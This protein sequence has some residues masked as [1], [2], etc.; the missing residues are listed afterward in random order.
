MSPLRTIAP[1][2]ALGLAACA[3]TGEGPGTE[4]LGTDVD[5]DGWLADAADPEARDCDDADATV[6]P[7]AAELCDDVDQDCDGHIDEDAV[8]RTTWYTDGDGDGWGDADSAELACDQP[9]GTVDRGGDCDDRAERVNPDA[10]EVCDP[11]R[12][13]EDCDGQADDQDPD[14]DPDAAGAGTWH[15]DADGDGFGDAEDPGA[16]YCH[17]P[18]GASLSFVQDASDCD[19]SREDVNPEGTEVCDEDDTDEDCDGLVDDE[20]DSLKTTSQALWAPDAD[21]DGY[22]DLRAAE[23]RCDAPPE[24]TVYWAE[25]AS[26][27]DDERAD[28]NPGAQEVCDGDDTDED[29]DGRADDDDSSVDVSTMDTWHVDQDGDGYGSP[30]LPT[31]DACDEP[32][33][34]SGRS[35]V[36]D[37]TDCDDSRADVNP[38][39]TEVCDEDDADEDCD[40]LTEDDDPGLDTSTWLAWYLDADEDGYGDASQL[41][42]ACEDPSTSAESWVALDTDCDD[43]E[44][45]TWPGAAETCDDGVDSD[46]DGQDDTCQQVDLSAAGLA[47]EGETSGNQAGFSV[48]WGDLDGDGALELL[49]GAVGQGDGGISAGAAYVADGTL[50]G[51]QDLASAWQLTGPVSGA[52]A[53]ASVAFLEDVDGDG[54]S[55]ALIGGYGARSGSAAAEGAAWL[56]LGPLTADLDLD[57][58]DG[59]AWGEASGDQAGFRVAAA[60]DRDGDGLGDWLVGAL[61]SGR[62]GTAGGAAYLFGGVI[63]GEVD[64]GEADAVFEA[65]YSSDRAGSALA[66][67]E[68]VDGDGVSDLL[69][70]AYSEDSASTNA[71]AAYLWTGAASGTLSL[72][73]ATAKLQGQRTNQAL[74]TS[75]LLADLDGDGTADVVLGAHGDDTNGNEAGAVFLFLGPVS[76]T[77]S[78]A[79]ADAVIYGETK[80]DHAGWTISSADLDGDGQEDLLLGAY[81]G[82][83]GEVDAG[84]AYGLLGPLSGAISPPQGDV[85]IDGT[86]AGQAAGYAIR[87]VDDLDGDGLDEVLLGAT[88]DDPSGGGAGA[89]LLFSGADLGL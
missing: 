23:L 80:G 74:G 69:I 56:L 42:E 79:S 46:C 36:A 76:G 84:R 2:V 45:S 54:L 30:T 7:G 17:D 40:G 58:A 66:G 59:I 87:G 32:P 73:D 21:G 77:V 27:C 43:A 47:W 8:D 61:S 28:V 12:T 67:G 44:G 57:S 70:G 71:G 6:H 9:V 13:D 41:T 83:E 35:Y 14:L 39:G 11:D 24:A 62:A 52:L 18:G 4:G 85:V 26:D 16:R 20:D 60:G 82:D 15:L 88:G 3:S 49:V 19:D 1:L 50:T 55:D 89:A 81:G 25:D 34:S 68:D 53:G 86:R 31:T 65:E 63:T 29:C 38:G 72:A 5:G 75:A 51:T 22:G 33:S 10:T 64:L 78:S 48:D 37:G